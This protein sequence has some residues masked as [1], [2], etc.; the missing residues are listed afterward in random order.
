MLDE[1]AIQINAVPALSVIWQ[2]NSSILC[3]LENFN[4]L[5]CSKIYF[6]KTKKF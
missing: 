2:T 4:P 6:S 3:E 5:M 1:I